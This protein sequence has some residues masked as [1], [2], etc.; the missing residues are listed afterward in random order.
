LEISNDNI[1]FLDISNHLN[2]ST[3]NSQGQSATFKVNCNDYYKFFRILQTGMNSSNK[4]Y[5]SIAGFEIYGIS[6]GKINN[7]IKIKEMNI[8]NSKIGKI[9][10]ELFSIQ[11]FEEDFF[12]EIIKNCFVQPFVN[13][14]NWWC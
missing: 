6:F 8:S 11:Y 7:E 1:I 5:F 4:T 10:G 2:D 13:N 9:I 12:L 14:F 3:L